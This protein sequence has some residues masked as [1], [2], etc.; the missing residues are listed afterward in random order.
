MPIMLINPVNKVGGD[1]VQL[2]QYKFE[3]NISSLG[4]IGI[5]TPCMMYLT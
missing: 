2:A 5:P 4:E 3:I 1:K